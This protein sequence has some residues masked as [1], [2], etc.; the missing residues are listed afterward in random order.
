MQGHSRLDV[1][2]IGHPA[3]RLHLDGPRLTRPLPCLGVRQAFGT[4]G[5]SDGETH[6]LTSAPFPAWDSTVAVYLEIQRHIC[7]PSRSVGWFSVGG[8]Q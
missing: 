6:I 7:T 3:V 8:Y 1:G 2:Y 4:C 5:W